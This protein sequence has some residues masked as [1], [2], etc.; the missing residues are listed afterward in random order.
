MTNMPSD[1]EQAYELGRAAER[2]KMA[3]LESLM[4][5]RNIAMKDAGVAV[6]VGPLTSGEQSLSKRGK[7]VVSPK[8]PKVA[9]AAKQAVGQRVSGVK[10]GIMDLI[11]VSPMSSA[12]I[13]AKSGFKATSVRGTLMTLKKNGLADN[14]NGLWYTPAAIPGNSET[15]SAGF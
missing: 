6:K 8:V 14:E 1:I 3:E 12:D 9:R 13:I 11:N 2:R 10:Q 4:A 7:I 5:S 15:A